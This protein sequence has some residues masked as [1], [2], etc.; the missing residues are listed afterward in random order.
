[1]VKPMSGSELVLLAI[2]DEQVLQL[3]GRALAAGS[4]TTAVARDRAAV[5]QEKGCGGLRVDSCR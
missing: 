4:F 2:D 3:F 5:G 1:M